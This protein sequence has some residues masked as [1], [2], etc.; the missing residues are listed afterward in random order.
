MLFNK[1]TYAKG[2]EKNEES[3][4]DF[5]WL[6]Y[7]STSKIGLSLREYGYLTFGNWMDLFEVHKKQHNFETNRGLY[8]IGE[9]PKV[10]SLDLI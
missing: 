4:I 9:M 6:Q 8:N 2:N 5:P 3:E 7:T 10:D 1:K